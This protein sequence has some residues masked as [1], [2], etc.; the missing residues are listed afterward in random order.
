M[1]S[2]QLKKIRINR[3]V[4]EMVYEVN[5]SEDLVETSRIGAITMS[6]NTATSVGVE[7]NYL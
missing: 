3:T 5:K 1:I 7:E 2:I 4:C 6:L